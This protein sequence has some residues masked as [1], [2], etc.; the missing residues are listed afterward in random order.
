M[1]G[2]VALV[3]WMTC[4]GIELKS[5][6]LESNASNANDFCLQ[7]NWKKI[8]LKS[9]WAFQVAFTFPRSAYLS[10]EHCSFWSL[11]Q[12][13]TNRSNPISWTIFWKVQSSQKLNAYFQTMSQCFSCPIRRLSVSWLVQ[14]Q[15]WQRH[16][17]DCSAEL[18]RSKCCQ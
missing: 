15:G 16:V 3:H 5:Y 1:Q 6:K 14:A 9:Q 8:V 17:S 10:M 4:N 7:K 2:T 18:F 12:A 11:S 13:F